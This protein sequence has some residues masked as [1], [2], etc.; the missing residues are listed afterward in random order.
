MRT[1]RCDLMDLLRRVPGRCRN[2][3]VPENLQSAPSANR[4]EPTRR[5]P[6]KKRAVTLP[7]HCTDVGSDRDVVTRPDVVNVYG[8]DRSRPGVVLASTRGVGRGDGWVTNVESAP[9]WGAELLC[10]ATSR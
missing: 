6:L 7:V 4:L 1:L 3:V 9:N 5:L 10:T 2:V 8:C